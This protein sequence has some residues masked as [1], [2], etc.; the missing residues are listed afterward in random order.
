MEI[1]EVAEI[2]GVP[3]SYRTLLYAV[4]EAVYLG[5]KYVG[6]MLDDGVG[7][8]LVVDQ[9][10]ESVE[11]ILLMRPVEY[12]LDFCHDIALYEV[13]V[14][15]RSYTYKICRIKDLSRA[16]EYFAKRA[17][18]HYELIGG[19]LEDFLDQALGR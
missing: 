11:E 16:K 13:T 10:R 17:L 9:V 12:N 6:L 14:E 1:S 15:G 5:K 2:I 19:N 4:S 3:G 7:V 8:I 18:Q